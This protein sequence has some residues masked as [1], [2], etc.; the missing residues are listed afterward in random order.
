MLDDFPKIFVS[1]LLSWMNWKFISSNSLEGI[2]LF[3]WGLAG[4]GGAEYLGPGHCM[5]PP[6]PAAAPALCVHCPPP[7]LGSASRA[8]GSPGWEASRLL[9][10]LQ[11]CSHICCRL[12]FSSSAQQPGASIYVLCPRIVEIS[13]SV[14]TCLFSV[15]HVKCLVARTQ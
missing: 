7:V 8:P 13:D 6:T 1:F 2:F 15:S 10:P 12:C 14:S 11:R 5:P 4:R 9:P 3:L